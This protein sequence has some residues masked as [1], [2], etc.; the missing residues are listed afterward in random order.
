[1]EYG[2]IELT[3]AHKPE[4]LALIATD[5]LRP[6]GILAEGTRYWGA[7]SEYKLVGIIGC[8]YENKCALL[9][10]ALVRREYRGQGIAARLTQTLLDA[11]RA[12]GI[13]TVYLFSTGA[14]DY[15]KRQGFTDAPVAEVVRNMPGAPQ[16]K[17][18]DRLGW[19]PAEAAY[20]YDL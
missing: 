9:R 4:A 20:R 10:S 14:G 6:E 3:P 7:F 1:M 8:E 17:L 11:A 12:S 18:F 19:L 2:I 13:K 5:D 15:W 16:V